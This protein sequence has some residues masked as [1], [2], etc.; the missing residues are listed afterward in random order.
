MKRFL[1]LIIVFLQIGYAF[2]QQ[3]DFYTIL[4]VNE[5]KSD[6]LEVGKNKV[7]KKVGDIV[8]ESDTIFHWTDST[9]SIEM[10][11]ERDGENYRWRASDYYYKINQKQEK[12][13]GPNYGITTQTRTKSIND[14]ILPNVETDNRRFDY[15]QDDNGDVIIPVKDVVNKNSAYYFKQGDK[16]FCAFN[17]TDSAVVILKKDQ[18]TDLIFDKGEAQLSVYYVSRYSDQP[19]KIHITDSLY[20]QKKYK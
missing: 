1:I 13:S 6:S 16:E 2:S 12:K 14:G 4:S 19:N 17:N 8:H 7:F 18:L 11:Y 3:K 9:Q 10:R 15:Y 5:K 20:I